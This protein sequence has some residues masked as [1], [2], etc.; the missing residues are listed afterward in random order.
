[1]NVNVVCTILESVKDCTAVAFLPDAAVLRWHC[2]HLSLVG[3]QSLGKCCKS[4]TNLD[5]CSKSVWI[6][7]E[8]L[9]QQVNVE[10]KM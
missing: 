9:L 10:K 8:I 5:K 7:E 3:C 6:I 1:M 4:R 2:C